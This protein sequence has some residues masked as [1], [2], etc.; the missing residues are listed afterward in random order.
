MTKALF[1]SPHLYQPT[2]LSKKATRDGYGDA[3][4]ELGRTNPNVVALTADLSESTRS[5][6]F[7]ESFPNRFF[8]VG[9]AEQNLIGMAAGMALNGKI[10]FVASY[11]VFS[12]GRNWDQLRVSVCYSKANVKIIGCHTG[13]TVGE[14]GA[15]HQALE[16]IAITRVLPN[17]TV[18]CPADYWQAFQAVT[19]AA[20]HEGPVYI[21]LTRAA[22]QIFTTARTPFAIGQA[23]VLRP[24]NDVTIIGCGPL[25]YEALLAAEQLE[26]HSH[27][28]VEVINM[29]TIK[30]LDERTLLN[31]VN[32]THAVVTLEEHQVVGGLGSAVAEVLAEN[33]PTP[34][35]FMGMHD[36]FGESGKA[37]QLLTKYHFTASH[38]MHAVRKVAARKQK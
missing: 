26:K 10:P 35:E 23:Q 22:S 27:L 24:G 34:I 14:D 7:Q 15:T 25:I 18:I 5:N 4:L 2:L 1:L 38:I 13:L 20:E 21:R 32:K 11:A 37:N 30:P 28:S 17:L 19:A 16:D 9:V 31:S 29:P 3:L 12:P 8:E 33:L 6:L 36:S